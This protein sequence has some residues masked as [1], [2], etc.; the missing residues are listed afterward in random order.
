MAVI[1]NGLSMMDFFDRTYAPLRLGAGAKSTRNKFRQSIA[2]LE[3][4]L[5]RTAYLA[6]LTDELVAAACNAKIQRG[7]SPATAN[8]IRGKINALWTLAA[9]RRVIDTYPTMPRLR[10]Y[11]RVPT[12]WSREQLQRL[13]A[14]CREEPGEVCGIPAGVWWLNLHGV[15][16]DTGA[17][18]GVI[19]AILKGKGRITGLEWVQIDLHER[20]VLLVAEHQKQKADQRF[21]LHADT[22]TALL[23]HQ[24]PRHDRWVFPWPWCEGTL[25]NRYKH[26]LRR[27]DLPAGRRDKFHKMRRSVAS[28]YEAAGGNATDLLGHSSRKVTRAYLDPLI[29]GPKQP[30][31]VLFRIG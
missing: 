19:V 12:A 5:G 21:P 1:A 22:A 6:D 3:S 29:V 20:T 26:I 27:A 30:A 14:A 16:W 28:W 23:L 7:R 13:W 9:K 18:I 11:V 2:L 31:D 24:R 4:I 8:G 10:E 15:L 17:R 25:Y